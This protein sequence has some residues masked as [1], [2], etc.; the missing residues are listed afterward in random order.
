M[1]SRLLAHRLFAS[2][3]GAP[4]ALRQPTSTR[5][6]MLGLACVLFCL[7]AV[8]ADPDHCGICGKSLGPTIY[9]TMDHVTHE[10]VFMCYACATCPD[11]CYICGLPA[12]VNPVK[13]SDGRFLCA[14]DAKQAVLDE[15]KAKEICEEVRDKIDRLFSRFLTL[16]STNTSVALVD[17]VDLYQE[18]AV[19]GN[20]FECPDILGYIHSQTNRTSMAHSISIMSALPEPEFR[21]TCAHE[22][23]HAWVF[24]HVSSARRKAL[25]RDAHEGFCELIAWL[26]MDS[27]HEEDQKAKMLRNTYTRGQIDLFIAA[28]K[29][30]GL[31]D[32][33]DWMRW[34]VNGRLK[35][36]DPGDIRN[37]EMPRVKQMAANNSVFYTATSERVPDKLVLK[38][39]SNARGQ[40]L[41]LINN[42][43]LAP[44]ESARIR[45]GATNV[46]IKCVAIGQQSVR[47][48]L[49]DSGKELELSLP[50]GR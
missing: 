47:V 42:Q 7:R 45:V 49:V 14:R 25:S 9:R 36:A 32:I 5:L 43:S 30:Y 17:R 2:A 19:T 11:E 16:P 44:G 33:L 41:A 39:I 27:L 23:A 22:Y 50:G 12:V 37:V 10:K 1:I 3:P 18:F 38:G 31:N 26:L 46:L 35:A 15:S 40:P 29:A 48:R 34:G 20:D 8:A 4:E 24:E 6:V 28:E 13:L 21:A